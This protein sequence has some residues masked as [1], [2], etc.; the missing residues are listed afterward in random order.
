MKY[1]GKV[2]TRAPE[3]LK[4]KASQPEIENN[5]VIEEEMV[6]GVKSSGSRAGV[7]GLFFFILSDV[8]G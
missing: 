7:W 8:N 2:H 4:R 6:S 1:M 3:L 5:K